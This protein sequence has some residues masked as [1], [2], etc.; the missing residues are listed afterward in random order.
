CQENLLNQ[1]EAIEAFLL[2]DGN[3][4]NTNSYKVNVNMSTPTLYLKNE[5]SELWGKHF[6]TK[7]ANGFNA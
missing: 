1:Q 7:L 5:K 3:N 2:T 6:V 4:A